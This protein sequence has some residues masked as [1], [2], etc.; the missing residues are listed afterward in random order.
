MTAQR[1]VPITATSR[2]TA[3][4]PNENGFPAAGGYNGYGYIAP[5]GYNHGGVEDLERI[6]MSFQSGIESE[7][8]WALSTMTRISTQTGFQLDQHP[9]IGEELIRFLTKS[10]QL[11]AEKKISLVDLDAINFSLDSLLTL[12]NLAQELTNQHWLSQLKHFKK[13]LVDIL[14]FLHGWFFNEASSL[15]YHLKQFEN[16][17]KEAL[18]YLLDLL[19]P[20]TC[21]YIDNTKH[22]PLF[23]L[24]LNIAVSTHDKAVFISSLTSLSHLLIISEEDE[25][26]DDVEAPVA[27]E[28]LKENET[29]EPISNAKTPNNCIDAIRDTHLEWFVNHLLIKDNEL[30]NAVFDFIKLYLFSK[31]LHVDANSVKSSQLLR[32][33]KLLQLS[34]AK[35]PNLTT[36]LKQLPSILLSNIPGVYDLRSIK[37]EEPTL[38]KRSHFSGVPATLPDLPLDLYEII[39]R[40]PEPLRATTWLRC[41]Y[42]PFYN[43][44][45]VNTISDEVLPGEVTQISLWKAYE[46][47]FQKVW[48]TPEKSHK[49]LLPA[50]DF[51]KNV[52]NAFPNSEAMVINL[53]VAE[54]EAPKK[55]FIIKGIQPRQFVTNIDDGNYEALRQP[56]NNANSFGSGQKLTVGHINHDEFNTALHN[57]NEK[58]LAQQVS[59]DHINQL[60]ELSFEILDYIVSELLENNYDEKVQTYFKLYNGEWL[61]NAIY[62]NPSLLESGLVNLNWLKYLL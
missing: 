10:F 19:E 17:F 16:Q 14:K 44:L 8:K 20:L 7:V 48:D 52:S 60:H 41:C 58:I 57:A 40:F 30:V 34:S 55:K 27:D 22:D 29:D 39:I 54:G 50:V 47:Q 6:T 45:E 24:L 56:L 38:T 26:E 59:K 36:L 42:E 5:I 1:L 51:I 32:L 21:Y 2:V 15:N 37:I 61:P 18:G 28:D 3:H 49:P 25:E 46:K 62:A 43:A 12:R 23:S 53:N 31:A 9:F 35:Q 13:S 4:I 11:I 33:K